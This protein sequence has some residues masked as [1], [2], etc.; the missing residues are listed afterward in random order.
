M[1]KVTD[2]VELLRVKQWIKNAFIFFPLIFSGQ[3]FVTDLALKALITFFSFCFI[4]SGIY[5]TNDYLDV[6]RD[7]NHPRKKNRP[8]LRYN[9]HPGLIVSIVGLFIAG[10]LGMAWLVQVSVVYAALSYILLN[11]I[12]NWIAKNIVLLDVIFIAVGFEIRIWAGALAAGILPSVWLQL[13]V[14]LLALFLGFTKR[15]HEISILKDKAFEHRMVLSH[16][17]MYLLDQIIV[18]CSTLT[19]IFYGLYALSVD[20]RAGEENSYMIYSIV[21]VIYG[22]FRYFYLVH[23][24]NL[25][26]DT[27]EIIF[28]DFPFF[29]NILLWGLYMALILYAPKIF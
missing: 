21:F 13:C 9:L 11:V 1:K 19:I 27:G 29:I 5:L 4:A 28:S 24:K 16:Y 20:L 7:R 3:F 12:Y 18:I 8:L 17:K 22:I 25:G 15:R 26:E 14:F 6:E 10:G 2:L 23:V